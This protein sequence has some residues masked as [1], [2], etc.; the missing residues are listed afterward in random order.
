MSKKKEEAVQ[1][2]KKKTPA[3]RNDVLKVSKS[4]KI[5]AILGEARYGIPR[6]KTILALGHAEDNYK[7]YG[8]LA[9]V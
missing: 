8:R 7:R 2:K 6:R 9:A 5:M 4:I 3:H 1:I